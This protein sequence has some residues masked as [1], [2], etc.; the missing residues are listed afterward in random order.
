M[1][2]PIILGFEGTQLTKNLCQHLQKTDPSGIVLFKRNIQSLEQT[3]RLVRDIREHLGD[4]I[5]AVDHEGGV[6]N[7]FPEDCPVPPSPLALNKAGQI[8]LIHKACRMQAELLSFLGIDLNFVPVVDLD[9]GSD[10]LAIGTRAFSKDPKEV[11][12]YGKACVEEH[13]KL[14]I[15]TVAKHFPGH[16]RTVSDSHFSVGQ[17]DLSKQDLWESDL[18][19]YQSL[20]HQDIPAI[21]TAHLYYPA[22]DN[23]YPATLSSTIINSFLRVKMQFK[24]LIISDCIE[25]AGISK[26]YSIKQM[27][28]LGVQAGIDIWITSFSLR[29]SYDFQIELK[30]ELDNQ[31]NED[32]EMREEIHQRLTKYLRRY[33]AFP[34]PVE[35]LISADETLSLHQ[36]TLTK[37]KSGKLDPGYTSFYLIELSNGENRGINTLTTWNVVTEQIKKKCTTLYENKIILHDEKDEFI[38]HINIANKSHCTILLLTANGFRQD[39]YTELISQLKK[40][41]SSIHIALLDSKDL[42]GFADHEWATW[43]FNA[44]TGKMIAE[45]LSQIIQESGSF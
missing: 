15:G 6:V 30:R 27:V 28:Q 41:E 29:K 12:E 4:I 40:A 14:S 23:T 22:L 11:I 37:L 25:M 18:V 20:I 1:K 21:M 7:R 35:T 16:G 17:V 32:I 36:A 33:C 42:S 39:S 13:R 9:A 24:G 44:W 8:E 5:V 2:S 38:H 10:N 26:K 45:N 3:K 34:K 19:P 31:L 43:G